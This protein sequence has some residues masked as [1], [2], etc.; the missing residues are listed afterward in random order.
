MTTI[1]IDGPKALH[2]EMRGLPGAG[3][4]GIETFLF[5][6]RPWRKKISERSRSI[7]V[8]GA[9]ARAST[10]RC[11]ASSIRPSA[12][13]TRASARAGGGQSGRRARAAR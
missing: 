8:D 11:S 1:S 13:S 7:S 3:T 10:A 5:R 4:S 6:Q 9:A 12:R 2:E